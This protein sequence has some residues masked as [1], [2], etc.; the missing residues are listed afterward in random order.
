V[1]IILNFRGPY[2]LFRV[3]IVSDSSCRCG[4]ALDNFK[5]FK[6]IHYRI[7]GITG[8]ELSEHE[9]HNIFIVEGIKESLVEDSQQKGKIISFPFLNRYTDILCMVGGI[10][11]QR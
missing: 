10:N 2:D 9:H 1:K 4:A 5:H 11:V 3:G 7:T 8:T 6:K